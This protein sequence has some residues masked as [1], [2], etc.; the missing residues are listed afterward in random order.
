M[1]DDNRFLILNQC[2]EE[3]TSSKVNDSPKV[4]VQ[5]PH[6]TQTTITKAIINQDGNNQSGQVSQVTTAL[7]PGVSKPTHGYKQRRSRSSSRETM[8]A[9]WD[10]SNQNQDMT[11]TPRYR[12]RRP[13]SPSRETAS[14]NWDKRNQTRDRRNQNR[15]T[16]P[17]RYHGSSQYHQPRYS[18]HQ[19][20]NNKH[21]QENKPNVTI[22]G[23]SILK[24]LDPK[25][26]SDKMTTRNCT[27]Y[28]IDEARYTLN[29]LTTTPDVIVLQQLSNDL[30]HK[31][32]DTCVE[33]LECLIKD[34]HE[35][36]QNDK[37]V[38]SLLPNRGDNPEYNKK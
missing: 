14:R 21:F 4:F 36:Y 10:R 19:S 38:I 16:S 3:S 26:F 2:E 28:T 11:P 5:E 12:Q 22:I 32:P 25:R 17:P 27:A 9:N 7:Y 34:T 30:K 35:V 23:T 8:S 13:R 6:T 15:D 37:F 31:H 29:N 1:K 33:D 18:N 24:N 20:S